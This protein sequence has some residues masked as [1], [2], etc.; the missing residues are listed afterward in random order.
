[1][2][3]QS[4]DLSRDIVDLSTT[5]THG[6]EPEQYRAISRRVQQV[7]GKS[8]SDSRARVGN[9]TRIACMNRQ[10][11]VHSIIAIAAFVVLFLTLTVTSYTRMSATSDEPEHLTAGYLALKTN[12]YRIDPEHPPFLRMWAALPLLMQHNMK[13][14]DTNIDKVDPVGWVSGAEPNELEYSYSFNYKLNDADHMLYPARFMIVLLGVLLGILIFSWARE[15]LGF[16]P[17][18]IALGFYTLEPNI[19]AHASLVTTDFGITCFLFG[20]TYFL[21]RT[22]R[23]LSLRNLAGLAAFSGLTAISKFSAVVLGPIVLVC[24][25]IRG[26]QRVPWPCTIGKLITIR[27]YSGR[28]VACAGILLLVTIACWAAIWAVYGFRYLP[29]QTPGWRYNLDEDAGLHSLSPTIADEVHWINANHLL[30]NVYSEGFLLQQLRSR[31]RYAFLDGKIRPN[32]W[33]YYFPFAFLIKTPISLIIFFLG[34]LVFCTVKWRSFWRDALFVLVP[35]SLYL[36]AAMSCDL[37]IGLRHILPIY[38]FVILLAALSATEFIRTKRRIAIPIVCML[39]VFWLFEFSRVY[40][41]DLAFFNS[42]I[43]GPQNGYKYLADSNV[44]WGQDLKGLK[45]WMDEQ[46]VSQ[47]NLAYFGPTPPSYYGIQN[48]YLPGSM[49]ASRLKEKFSPPQLP[50]YVAISTMVLDGVYLSNTARAY[51]APFADRKPIADIGYS[52][53]VYWVRDRW[54]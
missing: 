15:W 1:M 32:G 51:Y 33:W 38:P 9:P 11:R 6:S 14:P 30:P 40:P 49:N 41:H 53:R 26:L 25:V 16:W 13:L 36:A 31:G 8:S 23:C 20:S 42:F 2:S 28:A 29:S 39:C 34:G 7:S 43:G 48:V 37:N 17:A 47:V 52:I 44:D 4:A 22:T 21:W 10:Q 5:Q 46:G 35:L 24:L 19:L 54:W 18:V 50:G 3:K 45:R 27:G 12:D